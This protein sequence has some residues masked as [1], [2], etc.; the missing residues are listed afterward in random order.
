M[1]YQGEIRRIE[2]D[3]TTAAYWYRRAIRADQNLAGPRFRLAR[4]L[5]WQKQPDEVADLL[6][7]ELRLPCEDQTV[8]L[9]TGRMLLSLGECDEAVNCFLR[10]LDANPEQGQ[11]YFGMAAVLM[12]K[13]DAEGCVQFLEHAIGL[14]VNIMAAYTCTAMIYCSQKNYLRAAEVIKRAKAVTGNNWHLRLWTAKIAIQALK[15]NAIEHLANT[16]PRLF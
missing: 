13:H 16:L 7:E 15:Q 4:I 5:L 1:F 8:L 9:L 12:Q 3:F 6:K 2:N 11:A 10:V 14:D